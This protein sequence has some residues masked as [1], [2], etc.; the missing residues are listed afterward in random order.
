MSQADK[1]AQ[2]ER[3]PAMWDQQ[4]QADKPYLDELKSVI[5]I[6]LRAFAVLFAV[7]L[8]ASSVVDSQGI[9]RWLVWLVLPCSLGLAMYYWVKIKKFPY[10]SLVAFCVISLSSLLPP[11]WAGASTFLF[12]FVQA[13]YFGKMSK[14]ENRQWHATQKGNAAEHS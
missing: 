4:K 14:K 9:M 8:G 11:W 6:V 1:I 3:V 7:G 2:L 12:L 13:Y 5:R 10:P